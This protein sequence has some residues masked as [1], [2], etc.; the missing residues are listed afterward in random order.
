MLAQLLVLD[1]CSPAGFCLDGA[2]NQGDFA[3]M[4][5]WLLLF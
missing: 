1:V 3:V 2:G 4:V 5:F